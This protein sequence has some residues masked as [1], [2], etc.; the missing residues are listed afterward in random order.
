MSGPQNSERQLWAVMYHYVRDLPNTPYPRIKGM[1][2]ENFRQQVDLLKGR[3]E[4]ATLE[5]AL[6]F[7]GGRYRP[8]R[9]LCV[10]VFDDGLK[11]HYTEVTP[12]LAERSIEGLFFVITGCVEENKVATV[13]K[14]HFLLAALDFAEYKQAFLER[15]AEISP[16]T[17]TEVD[18]EKVKATYR[19]DTSDI[20]AFKYL[21][22]FR[23]TEAQRE[24]IL[25][26]LFARYLGD[27]KQFASELYVNW[28]EARRMQD[29]GMLI[30]GHTHSHVALSTMGDPQQQADL[31]KCSE[32]LHKRLKP[33]ALWPFSYPYGQ[34]HSF[35]E[36]TVQTLQD[37]N[38]ACG[39]VTEVGSNEVS[40]DLYR[41]RR[42]D[43]K[44]VK[45]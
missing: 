10:L 17:D 4:M 15:L 39:F 43:P 20:A 9:D 29:A 38:F 44:D 34:A 14:N 6:D 12:I 2:T 13:H 30:G 21:L 22:N 40:R 16:E 1:L 33:Q 35:N 37:L 8:D 28:D 19:W 11:E 42:I 32:L 31:H 18:I 41:I 24:Q 7:L 45:E 3:Y 5:S 36:V 26:D 27:E 23:L 25:N